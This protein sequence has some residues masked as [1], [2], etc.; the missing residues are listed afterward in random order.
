MKQLSPC[1]SGVQAS[2]FVRTASNAV[3]ICFALTGAEPRRYTP[4]LSSNG[5]IS[6][7]LTC[8]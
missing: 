2:P 7:L 6:F 4:C 1:F 8:V 5:T 3:I